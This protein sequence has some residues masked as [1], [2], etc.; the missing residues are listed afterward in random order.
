MD[1]VYF[2]RCYW[3][4]LLL[5]D[6]QHCFNFSFSLKLFFSIEASSS[7]RFSFIGW[8]QNRRDATSSLVNRIQIKVEKE[9]KKKKLEL[10]LVTKIVFDST[11]HFTL[12]FFF[13]R[14]QSKIWVIKYILL[15]CYSNFSRYS[16]WIYAS[17]WCILIELW[18]KKKINYFVLLMKLFTSLLTLS[19]IRHGKIIQ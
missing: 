13:S 6:S 3:R 16:S 9:K 1:C 14:L 4:A 15:G 8:R 19:L 7:S 12:E 2:I 17:V 5:F 18:I 11:V 10:W